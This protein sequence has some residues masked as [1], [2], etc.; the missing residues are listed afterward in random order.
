MGILRGLDLSRKKT[1][2]LFAT[3]IFMLATSPVLMFSAR[4]AGSMAGTAYAVGS[5]VFMLG[6][7]ALTFA[8]FVIDKR[9]RYLPNF[10]S[11][12]SMCA[13]V[14]SACGFVLAWARDPNV[15]ISTLVGALVGVIVTKMELLTNPSRGNPASRKSRDSRP[16]RAIAPPAS[17]PQRVR[18]QPR[19]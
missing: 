13:V 17:K 4:V 9:N 8:M 3:G 16:K 1:T 19:P 14:V 6:G 15:F 5:I 12:V 7:A 10:A 2:G 18:R 11:Y